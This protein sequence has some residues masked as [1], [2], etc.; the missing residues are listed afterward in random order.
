[1]R[2]AT[3]LLSAGILGTA[4]AAPPAGAE[5][6]PRYGAWAGAQTSAEVKALIDQLNALID[7]ADKAQAA[8]PQFI[9]DLRAALD[10]FQ[11]PWQVR[12]LQ[13]DFRDGNYTAN[14]AWTVS[15]GQFK[16][17]LRGSSS[18]GLRSQVALPGTQA[19]GKDV[20]AALLGALLQQPA[21]T[22]KYASIFTPVKITN[23]FA[24][25]F[26]L[27]SKEKGGRLDLGPYQGSAGNVAY[28][29][30][31]FPGAQPSLQLLRI[32]SQGT[33]VIASHNAALN[34]E[35]G[36]LHVIEWTR[37]RAG[38]MTVA[39]DGKT[40]ITAS[41]RGIR[42]PFD[43]FLMINSGGSYWLR[44]ITIDGVKS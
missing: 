42:D 25:R 39:L 15:A 23:A 20:A 44:S 1:M 9:E 3:L 4:L 38:A 31:Y 30:A 6:Q 10:N 16:V 43:G 35:D 22:A 37:D 5:E 14:P 33:T 36:A 2:L 34:L 21:A 24:M 40:L 18:I 7:E 11:N 26:E 41:D 13:D 32:G 19:S 27:Y 17:D 8:D 28:R 12:L 29:I